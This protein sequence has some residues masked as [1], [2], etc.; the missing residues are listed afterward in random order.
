MK[1]I[2]SVVLALLICS[3]AFARHKHKRKQKKPGNIISVSVRHPGCYGRCPDYIVE[4]NNLGIATYTAKRFNP[5]TGVFQK[6]IGIDKAQEIFNMVN[7]YRVDTCKRMYRALV[8]DI[9]GF[10]IT[11][12]YN[13]SSKMINNANF[14]PLFLKQIANSVDEAGKKTDNTWQ[15]VNLPDTK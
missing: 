12:V 2:I 3:L 1:K 13:D 11:I 6:N 4:I 9:P 10:I 7:T 15:K 14:G 5:D 8:S